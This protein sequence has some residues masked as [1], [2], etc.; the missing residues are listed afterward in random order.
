MWGCWGK[1]GVVFEGPG[2]A[3]QGAEEWLALGVSVGSPDSHTVVVELVSASRLARHQALSL[4][5][6]HQAYGAL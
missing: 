3:A 2:D 5:H 4:H 1:A 6:A